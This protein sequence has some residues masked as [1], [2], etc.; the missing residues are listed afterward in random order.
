MPSNTKK[1][2]HLDGVF[3]I[4]SYD[5]VPKLQ[6]LLM[7][8]TFKVSTVHYLQDLTSA[9]IQ[10]SNTWTIWILSTLSFDGPW[11]CIQH[12]S[13]Y[14]FVYYCEWYNMT[15][16]LKD[17]FCYLDFIAFLFAWIPFC[18]RGLRS[19]VFGCWYFSNLLII[20]FIL[21]AL[22]WISPN[23]WHFHAT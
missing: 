3:N 5:I 8:S 1:S 20:V 4:V 15:E 9:V 10:F 6:D 21:S 16:K 23:G 17:L 2:V 7:A 11:R 18:Y 12:G 13:V 14:V 19:S 22:C